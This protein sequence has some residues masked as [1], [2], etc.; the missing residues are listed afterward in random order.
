LFADT[1]SVAQGDSIFQQHFGTAYAMTDYTSDSHNVYFTT[2][3]LPSSEF[4]VIGSVV[5][6]NSSAS[7]DPVKMPDV[8]GRTEGSLEHMDYNFDQ[9][10][11]YSDIDF[12]L[13]QVHL[14]CEYRLSPVWN[15][16]LSGAIADLQDDAP[17]V[18]GDETGTIYVVRAGARMGF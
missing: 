8:G 17:Y 12:T 3:Y 1:V 5:F 14:G 2:T 16:T 7:L 4:K 11:K 10:H 13:W 6:N 18:Y 15:L 9:V